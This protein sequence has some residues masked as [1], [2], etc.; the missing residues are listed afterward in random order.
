MPAPRRQKNNKAHDAERSVRVP[1]LRILCLRAGPGSRSARGQSPWL[2][3]RRSQR[4]GDALRARSGRITP[5]RGREKQEGE[6]DR[7]S[8]SVV[9]VRTTARV[10][11]ARTLRPDPRLQAIVN[12]QE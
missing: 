2:S 7:A 3:A 12:R 5:S 10:R 1:S 6:D 8:P 11:A 4:R 9:A